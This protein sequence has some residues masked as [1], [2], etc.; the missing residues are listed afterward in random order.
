VNGEGGYMAAQTAD[1]TLLELGYAICGALDRGTPVS[2]IANV[3]Q[4]NDVT[5]DLFAATMA[6]AALYLCP[7]H[8]GDD[9]IDWTTVG[10]LL[11][12]AA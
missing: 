1:A 4:Q 12:W 10:W 8:G 6:G 3:A 7:Q 2:E 11:L 9:L 5:P